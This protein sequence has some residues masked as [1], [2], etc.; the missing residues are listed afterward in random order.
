MNPMR[1]RMVS[2]LGKYR[3]SSHHSYLQNDR[4]EWLS[5][6][7]IANMFG[8]TQ[9]ESRL[10]YSKFMSLPT[11]ASM[12][13][14]LRGGNESDERLLGEDAWRETVASGVVQAPKFKDIDDLIKEF[15]NRH[16]ITEAE[17]ASTS[18]SRKNSEFRARL[19]IEATEQLLATVTEIARRFGRAHSGLSRAMTRL[20]DRNQ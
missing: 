20:R 6:E 10:A 13:Q 9:R 14:L 1:A 15:C 8:S 5:T 3:W 4:A 11:S 19:A 18:R 17:L 7:T 2:E 12:I 16:S